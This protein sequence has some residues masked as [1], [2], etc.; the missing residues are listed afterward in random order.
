M[1]KN[2]YKKLNLG[3]GEDIKHGWVNVDSVNNEG[4]NKV[5]NLNEFPYPFKNNEFDYIL[6]SSILEHLDYPEKVIEE[7]W[8]IS[9]NNA[10]ILIIVPHFSCW[11]TWGDITHKR[12]FNHTSLFCFS[13]KQNSKKSGS[14]INKRIELF[15]ICSKIQFGKIKK[16]FG[17]SFFVNL[18]NITRGFYE[19]HFAYI[20]PAQN[21]YFKLRALKG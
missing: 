8:R 2:N 10:H 3:C 12:G 7:V 13:D 21:L 1:K 14:L 17:F 11:Q 20:F 18:H 5:W 6:M 16:M 19:R 15:H 4:I 9:K